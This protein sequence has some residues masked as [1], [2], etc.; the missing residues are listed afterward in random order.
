MLQFDFT[1]FQ[2][3]R[4]PF[5]FVARNPKDETNLLVAVAHDKEWSFGL[6]TEET[7]SISKIVEA[8]PIFVVDSKKI[9][10]DTIPFIHKQDF[11][12]IKC[13]EDLMAKL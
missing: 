2:T 13:S 6:R 3:K 9:C 10:D 1:I 12:S 7:M 11:E 5:D 4:A 8:Q